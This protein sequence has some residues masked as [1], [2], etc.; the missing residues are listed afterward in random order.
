LRIKV[1][2]L[3]ALLTVLALAY[4]RPFLGATESL[5][6]YVWD[7]ALCDIEVSYPDNFRGGTFVVNVT[8]SNFNKDHSLFGYLESELGDEGVYVDCYK[9]IIAARIVY[10]EGVKSPVKW[11]AVKESQSGSLKEDLEGRVITFRFHTPK[12]IRPGGVFILLCFW[13]TPVVT[14]DTY[15]SYDGT[16]YYRISDV[17]IC[18]QQLVWIVPG[19]YVPPS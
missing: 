7:E 9:F 18:E 13:L 8:I 3:L 4:T 14:L 10:G 1:L 6:W 17:P 12:R 16:M 19:P 15:R 2:P 5:T 11:F